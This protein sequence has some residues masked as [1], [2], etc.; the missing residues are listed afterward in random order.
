VYV[1]L[2]QMKGLS[3]SKI[4]SENELKKTSGREL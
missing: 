3:V 1:I 2:K 4:V